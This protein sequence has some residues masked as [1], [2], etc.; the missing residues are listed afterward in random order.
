MCF[1]LC[2]ALILVLVKDEAFI[3]VDNLANAA[4]LIDEVAASVDLVLAW[5][6]RGFIRA[7]WSTHP[8]LSRVLPKTGRGGRLDSGMLVDIVAGGIN[9]GLI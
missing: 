4:I 6:I 7:G 1:Q 5:G 9:R 2:D 3:R 8:R